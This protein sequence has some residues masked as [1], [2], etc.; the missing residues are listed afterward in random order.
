LVS[1]EKRL[2]KRFSKVVAPAGTGVDLPNASNVRDFARKD[3][4]T[5]TQG[6]MLYND[7]T[8]WV[9]L[10]K[11]TADQVLT[12]ND[13]ATAPNWEAAA[14]GSSGALTHVETKTFEDQT[15][16]TFSGLSGKRFLVSL[17]CFNEKNASIWYVRFNGDSSATYSHKAV[18]NGGAA[19]SSTGQTEAL[20]LNTSS[21][22]QHLIVDF[23]AALCT[24]G[25]TRHAMM[26]GKASHGGGNGN[27]VEFAGEW[28]TDAANIT[29]IE[30]FSDVANSM[31]G[32]ISLY[33]LSE[34]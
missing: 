28:G 5:H 32:V 6:D 34:S 23:M 17:R 25:T 33:E 1:R 15:T 4:G 11:G 8:G 20:I 9:K 2:V 29:S 31:S 19:A 10:A 18:Y 3:R 26:N 22:T 27:I 24:D 7:G 30:I 13:A 14:G 12:M 16:Q 21:G